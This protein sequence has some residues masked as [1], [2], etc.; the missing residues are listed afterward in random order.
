MDDV[1]GGSVSG[2][3]SGRSCGASDADVE[4]VLVRL[5]VVSPLLKRCEEAM[6]EFD[7]ISPGWD[8]VK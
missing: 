5:C 6:R 2:P 8:P 7:A 4:V 1:L 3:G